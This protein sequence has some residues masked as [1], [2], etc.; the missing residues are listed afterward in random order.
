[1]EVLFTSTFVA[2]RGN[3]PLNF[4]KKEFLLLTVTEKPAHYHSKNIIGH[5]K[6]FQLNVFRQKIVSNHD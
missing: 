4:V 5:K 3:S 1:M 2:T 6:D